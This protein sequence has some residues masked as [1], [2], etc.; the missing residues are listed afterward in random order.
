MPPQ[1]CD[2]IESDMMR[3]ED[4]CLLGYGVVLCGILMAVL[5]EIPASIFEIGWQVLMI[6]CLRRLNFPNNTENLKLHVGFV[7]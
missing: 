3:F 2:L 1:S 4:Y 7:F 5:G 6:S